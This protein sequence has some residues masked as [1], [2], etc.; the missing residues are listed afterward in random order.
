MTRPLPFEF[1]TM[2]YGSIFIDCLFQTHCLA[3]LSNLSIHSYLDSTEYLEFAKRLS[4]NNKCVRD[5]AFK[6]LR[7]FLRSRKEMTPLDFQKIWKTIFYCYWMTD[8]PVF[9]AEVAQE[10]ADTVHELNTT[11]AVGYYGGFLSTFG[12]EWAGLDRHRMDKYFLIVR[13]VVTQMFFYL[14]NRNWDEDVISELNESIHINLT[15]EADGKYRG[16]ALHWYEVVMS[17]LCNA[18][19]TST[20]SSTHAADATTAIGAPK[21]STLG[22]FV[23]KGSERGAVIPP[24]SFIAL[25]SPVVRLLVE[26]SDSMLIKIAFDYAVGALKRS[27]D[28]LIKFRAQQKRAA[29][30]KA[31]EADG[32]DDEDED[33]D[34]GEPISPSEPMLALGASVAGATDSFAKYVF[35]LAADPE[36]NVTPRARKYLYSLRSVLINI[37]ETASR[38]GLFKKQKTSA[39]S[40][41]VAAAP[42]AAAPAPVPGQKRKE[43]ESSTPAAPVT[44]ASKSAETAQKDAKAT[45]KAAEKVVEKVAEKPSTKQAKVVQAP[46][47]T[48]EETKKETKKEETKKDEKKKATA[49]VPT[50]APAPANKGKGK[51][52]FM[53]AAD[54]GDDDDD[55][56]EARELAM[57]KQMNDAADDDEEEEEEDEEEDEDGFMDFDED[58]D[59]FMDF[60][61]DE[62][63]FMDFEE[64]EDMEEE[65]DEEEEEEEIPAPVI[66]KSKQQQQQQPPQQQQQQQQQKGKS[67]QLP[68][69]PA[70]TPA[71]TPVKKSPTPSSNI[72]TTINTKNMNNNTKAAPVST[73]KP[74]DAKT[75]SSSSSSSSSSTPTRP[76]SAQASLM[77]SQDAFK[78]PAPK[79][80][81]SSTT[82]STPASTTISTPTTSSTTAVKA[83]PSKASAAPASA[84]ASASPSTPAA[85]AKPVAAS[86]VTA[87]PIVYGTPSGK[88]GVSFH[89]VSNKVQ[90]FKRGS[91]IENPVPAEELLTRSARKGLIKRTSTLA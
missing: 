84:P 65:E 83:T 11:M 39:K 34:E 56:E 17:C 53:S 25:M 37:H 27:V 20:A 14:K 43:T 61:E 10:I 58:E 74:S 60:D 1:S 72:P 52:M 80:A 59:G 36:L 81:P 5:A 15:F 32:D 2:L 63:G 12:K 38:A 6:S 62:D 54:L 90:T 82:K 26:T 91:L 64:D 4:H 18:L 89:L 48:K 24:Q 35:E 75:S 69:P 86:Q 71:P 76:S 7:G 13:K 28:T 66:K 67:K 87:A 31:S 50:P 79:V 16:L 3:S 19:A 47:E 42:A 41:T 9:Q 78:A 77:P 55:D 88:K 45:P 57:F 51:M 49:P 68:P 30:K 22:S 23:A 33:E 29:R 8:K 73:T 21:A 85:P 40:T 44:K 46:K 70:P